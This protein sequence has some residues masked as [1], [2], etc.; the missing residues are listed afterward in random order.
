MQVIAPLKAADIKV[1]WHSDGNVAD[2][3]DDAVACGFDGINPIDPSAGMDIAAIRAR[4][5]DLLLVGNVDGM[6]TLPFGAE[7]DVREE[8]RRCI[9]AT[10][11]R[12]HLLQCG[13]GQIMPDVP[14]ENVI[15]YLDEARRF[16][17]TFVGQKPFVP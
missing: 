12:G 1:I 2:V 17:R 3:L 7:K 9:R 4:Y 10:G 16:S 6:K 11:G 14:A 15:A 8:V 13:C 5:P